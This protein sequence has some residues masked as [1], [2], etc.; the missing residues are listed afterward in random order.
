MIM[1]TMQIARRK[2]LLIDPRFSAET[3]E[4]FLN[5]SGYE[6]TRCCYC[7]EDAMGLVRKNRYDAVV[8]YLDLI[9]EAELLG[10]LRELQPDAK[11]I[12]YSSPLNLQ[13]NSGPIQ[14]SG[15]VPPEMPAMPDEI[16]A[17]LR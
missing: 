14:Q 3:V 8:W 15:A 6:V 17:A 12:A 16:A 4:E 9:D 11:I 1:M 2:V 5:Y 13:A 10:D 7:P